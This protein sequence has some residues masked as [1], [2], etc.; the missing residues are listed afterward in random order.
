[1]IRVAVLAGS[2]LTVSGVIYCSIEQP[3]QNRSSFFIPEW[4][5]FQVK[6][7]LLCG[8]NDFISN[9]G[10]SIDEEGIC[11]STLPQRTFRY[12]W[13]GVVRSADLSLALVKDNQTNKE[14]ILA[15]GDLI[16]ESECYAVGSINNET[17][18]LFSEKR[19]FRKVLPYGKKLQEDPAWKVEFPNGD[20][21]VM[22]KGDIV[23][24]AEEKW[25][26][27]ESSSDPPR[28]LIQRLDSYHVSDSPFNTTDANSL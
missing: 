12:S 27:T 4:E 1:V 19:D 3:R 20:T 28:V 26:L 2:L 15:E 22:K 6:P 7:E 8:E 17:M 18:S 11:V 14:W 21:F 10:C 16:P 13:I 24:V 25:K 23:S 5:A 9:T